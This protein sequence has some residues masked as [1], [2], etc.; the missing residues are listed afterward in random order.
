M[1]VAVCGDLIGPVVCVMGKVA[2]YESPAFPNKLWLNH[3]DGEGGCFDRAEVEAVM[4]KGPEPL[5]RY[6]WE[7]F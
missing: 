5:E 2:V 6:F 7:R 3:I 4:E 1:T